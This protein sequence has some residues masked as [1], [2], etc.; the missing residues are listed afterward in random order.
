M[1]RVDEQP[2]FAVVAQGNLELLRDMQ[3]ALKR[4]DVRAELMQP[5]Q[6]CGSS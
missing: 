2:E 4:N 3:S 6:G 5:P 1:A